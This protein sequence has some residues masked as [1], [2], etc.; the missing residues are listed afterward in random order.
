MPQLLSEFRVQ[1]AGRGRKPEEWK[2]RPGKTE[3]HLFDVLVGCAVAASVCGLQ[4]SSSG[5]PVLGPIEE[6]PLR[7]SEL[8]RGEGL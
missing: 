2:M 6:K 8:Q 5:E 7:L 4:W 1:T 3:N